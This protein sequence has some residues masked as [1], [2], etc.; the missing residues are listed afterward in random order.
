MT[1][2]QIR[3]TL[4]PRTI[5][6]LV[7]CQSILSGATML[8]GAGAFSEVI[9]VRQAGLAVVAVASI[10][11][12][13]QSLLARHTGQVIEHAAE[14]TESTGAASV[15]ATNGLAR[16]EAKVAEIQRRQPGQG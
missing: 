10:Q 1:T 8:V 5:K 7:I 15:R 3:I 12:V 4:S 14:V 16:V 2:D 6:N 9:G 13:I 11:A